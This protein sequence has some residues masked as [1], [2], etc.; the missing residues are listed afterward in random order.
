[1]KFIILYISYLICNIASSVMSTK[2]QTSTN[3]SNGIFGSFK[4][5]NHNDKV[6]LKVSK[7]EIKAKTNNKDIAPS[8]S[9][10]DI[11]MDGA[12]K[13][14]QNSLSK[15]DTD[16]KTPGN[17]ELGP[18]PYFTGW[19]Q[20][21][22]W[23]SNKTNLKKPT[24]FFKNMEFFEQQ[25]LSYGKTPVPDFTKKDANGEYINIPNAT[26]FYATMFERSLNVANSKD[27]SIFDDN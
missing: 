6:Q 22:K 5:F 1:M 23:S 21:F 26:H 12:F 10:G 3:T 24:T 4:M 25:K 11:A 13:G 19:I 18:A 16:K 2:T 7:V 27:V 20:Y 17:I 8:V 15:L 9:V 14:I